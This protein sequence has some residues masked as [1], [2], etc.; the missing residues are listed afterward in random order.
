[1]KFTQDPS[2]A[3][4]I[5]A[6]DRGSIKIGDTIHSNHLVLH[7]HGIGPE[8]PVSTVNDLHFSD[9]ADHIDEKTEIVLLGTG[10]QTV[11]PPR[12]IVFAMARQGCGFEF[13]ETPAACRT[14]N[15]LASEDRNVSAFLLI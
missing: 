1:M 6:V 14:F 10:W 5:R 11:V 4:T 2:S 8:W 15:I 9:F 13:M 12:E 7:A 3:V